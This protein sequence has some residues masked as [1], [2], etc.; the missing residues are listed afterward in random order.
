MVQGILISLLNPVLALV[1]S[2]LF[3]KLWLERPTHRH[4]LFF[5]TGYLAYA[6]TFSLQAMDWPFGYPA[7]G[8]LSNL[9]ILYAY[10]AVIHG[11]MLRRGQP[12]P[13]LAL[14][15]LGAIGFAGQ[16]WFSVIVP[17]MTGRIYAVN[18]C[19]GAMMLVA[20]AI[21]HTFRNKTPV[22]R[23]LL[24]VTLIIGLYSF[25]RTIGVSL[26]EGHI[27]DRAHYVG[28]LTWL[29]L[30]FSAA[31]F[32]LLFALTLVYMVVLDAMQDL[33]AE[34]MTDLLSGLLNRR[35]FEEHGRKTL[36][37]AN[38]IGIPVAL[39]ICDIDHFKSVNDRFG[40]ACGDQVITAFGRC[41]SNAAGGEHVTARIGGEEFAVVLAGANLKSGRLFAE[42]VRNACSTLKVPGLPENCAVTASF[43]VAEMQAGEDLTSLMRRADAALYEAKRRGR[44]RV[45]SA[46][47][48]I[49]KT[50]TDYDP[51]VSPARAKG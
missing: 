12:T 9:F 34:S 27:V 35:G 36:A 31:F 16:F 13:F 44:D 37:Y 40:H 43:G 8:L 42:A 18:F 47:T 50:G 2:G 33:R 17:D 14:G 6:I 38:G 20:A 24:A 3:L 19:Y 5:F 10:M 48:Q 30:N 39:L 21:M 49:A 11:I 29:V 46:E 51:P 32:A 22:E 7:N 45:R 4:I 28:S 23:V 1:L 25:V 15:I 26:A 41:L